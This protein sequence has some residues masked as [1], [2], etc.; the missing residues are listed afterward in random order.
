MSPQVLVE[1]HNIAPEQSGRVWRGKL[2]MPTNNSSA[3]IC[4]EGVAGSCAMGRVL[5]RSARGSSRLMGPQRADASVTLKN[6]ILW[7]NSGGYEGQAECRSRS[8]EIGQC[9][10]QIQRHARHRHC[11]QRHGSDNAARDP[12][13]PMA[14]FLVA[15]AHR[16]SCASIAGPQYP[17]RR[18][19]RTEDSPSGR[20]LDWFI[21]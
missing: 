19:E 20:H 11:T 8:P 12:G 17:R 5:Q 4:L 18:P 14:C 6:S 15:H 10:N 9:L 21:G 1:C 3:R 2:W 13:D 7:S 16:R